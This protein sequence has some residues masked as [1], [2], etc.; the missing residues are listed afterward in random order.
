MT[1]AVTGWEIG[2]G[3]GSDH[4]DHYFTIM[5][6]EFLTVRAGLKGFSD[7]VEDTGGA[8]WILGILNQLS[9]STED[10]YE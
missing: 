3:E 4:S 9:F 2:L 6:R 7:S 10:E 8:G 5:E 1:E